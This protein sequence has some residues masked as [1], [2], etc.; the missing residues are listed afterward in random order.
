MIQVQIRVPQEAPNW[1]TT[2][3]LPLYI[4]PRKDAACALDKSGEQRNLMFIPAG[5]LVLCM[6]IRR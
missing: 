2:L 5:I 4:Q 3:R 1:V 6:Y